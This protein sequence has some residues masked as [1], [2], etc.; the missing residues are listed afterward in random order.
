MSSQLQRLNRSRSK[1]LDRRL[2]EETFPI[3]E[4]SKETTKEKNIRHGN[5]SALHVWWARKPLG[6]S[7]ATCFASLIPAPLDQGELQRKKALVVK[8]S[9]FGDA[10][11]RKIL[12]GAKK[13]LGETKAMSSTDFDSLVQ[14]VRSGLDLSLNGAQLLEH[15]ASGGRRI[16]VQGLA[17]GA[18]RRQKTGIAPA[19]FQFTVFGFYFE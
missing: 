18:N 8:L 16:E 2:I 1:V 13:Y 9:K 7:R 14:A 19:P 12:D 10:L 11:D 4:V 5:I 17:R 6:S 15:V 3:S